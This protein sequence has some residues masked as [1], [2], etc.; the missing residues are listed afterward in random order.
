LI[1]IAGGLFYPV[2]ATVPR[3]ELRFAG[4]PGIGT[5]NALDWMRYGTIDRPDRTGVI[6]FADDL[7]A[8]EWFNGNVKGTP[9]IAEASIGPYR[10]NGSRIS[11]AT[12]LPTIIGWDRHERQ[13]RYQS[14]I[15][16][17]FLD[18]RTLYDSASPQE[19]LDILREYDVEYV[20]VGDVERYAA[21][22]GEPYA[23]AA[24][25]AAFDELVGNGLEIAF[26][27]GTTTVY[28]LTATF[29]TTGSE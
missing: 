17:R 24:G 26:Q 4:H 20:I 18:V 6:Q 9:V 10:G 2:L 21:W 7:A 8:I 29:G 1:L 14:D 22:G 3:L 5:L 16:P 15:D 11:I 25:I 19:K 23:S 27:S 12:G 28:R 13:Q